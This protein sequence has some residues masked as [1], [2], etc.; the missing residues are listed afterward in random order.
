[1]PSHPAVGNRPLPQQRNVGL[2]R[3]PPKASQSAAQ[4]SSSV[5][6]RGRK[7]A[8]DADGA[9]EGADSRV[10]DGPSKW[11]KTLTGTLAVPPFGPALQS[12]ETGHQSPQ[13]YKQS[14]ADLSGKRTKTDQNIPFPSRPGHNGVGLGVTAQLGVEEPA[15][16]Q[17]AELRL[18]TGEAPVMARRYPQARKFGALCCWH[19]SNWRYRTRRLLL[20]EGRAGRRQPRRANHQ[21]GL[22]EQVAAVKRDEYGSALDMVTPEKTWWPSDVVFSVCHASRKEA[23]DR[24]RNG[25]FHL[26]AS[27]SPDH[28]QYPKRVF[29]AGTGRSILAYA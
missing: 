4:S 6:Q 25:S 1:M 3:P 7:R 24:S 27:S 18:Y 22:P 12:P 29:L 26:Q 9:T 2:A 16:G 8:L 21:I 11:R 17:K 20:L 23:N 15:V 28:E 10:Q 13:I 19:L 14:Q 5:P